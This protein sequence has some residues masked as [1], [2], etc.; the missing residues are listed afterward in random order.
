[1]SGIMM[2]ILGSG[3]GGAESGWVLEIVP[4]STDAGTAMLK[5]V[6]E[7]SDGSFI[8]VGN[9]NSQALTLKFTADGTVSS[10][11]KVTQVGGSYSV[12][13]STVIEDSNNDVWIG[14]YW[15]S[16]QDVPGEAGWFAR[17]DDGDPQASI[18]AYQNTNSRGGDMSIAY[19]PDENRVH[20]AFDGWT[21]S[22]RSVELQKFNLAGTRQWDYRISFNASNSVRYIHWETNN[23]R[24]GYTGNLLVSMITTI[25]A[26][27]GHYA[28]DLVVVDTNGDPQATYR[29]TS[30]TT[31]T[32][33]GE[34]QCIASD[35]SFIYDIGYTEDTS[36]GN[37]HNNM[38]IRKI[39]KAT[40]A[41]AWERF[42]LNKI[43]STY[44]QSGG[45]GIA[46][47]SS[48]NVYATSRHGGGDQHDVLWK[49][50]S[51]GT[52]QWAIRL[53][54]T[55]SYTCVLNAITVGS[56][57][58]IY[59]GGYTQSS[60]TNNAIMF[61]IPP[62]GVSAGTYGDYTVSTPS[63]G[64][65]TGFLTFSDNGGS[66]NNGA[67]QTVSPSNTDG[68]VSSTNTKTDL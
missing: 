50:N 17:T 29:S 67:T 45:R 22:R 3:A 32:G 2:Q 14:G 40:G 56:D 15:Y 52:L 26:G 58:F 37:G 43:G 9:A 28:H 25:S 65:A 41:L 55:G 64:Q 53:G 51:S 62:D 46:V 1:M 24:A 47:D 34:G 10:L 23:N 49:F 61:K 6:M 8:A 4:S 54:R 44:Y 19:D 12:T 31:N 13:A 27:V 20:T 11:H 16:N 57:G 66:V 63:Y 30:S 36:L 60:S 39:N 48:G 5:A 21:G 59:T 33:S 18:Q 68:A 35:A 7:K 42:Y 38:H